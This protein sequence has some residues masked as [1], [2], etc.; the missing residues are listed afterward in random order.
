MKDWKQD[1]YIWW[2]TEISWC[3]QESPGMKPDSFGLSKLFSI[4]C[5]EILSKIVS[6][7]CLSQVG[8]RE[9]GL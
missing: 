2:V 8:K 5:W 1:S 9:T 4:K 3:I 6:S 7:K